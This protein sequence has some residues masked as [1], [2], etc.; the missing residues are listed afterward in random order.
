[1]IKI[2]RILVRNYR[3]IKEIEFTLDSFVAFVGYNNSG[4]SNCMRA[5]NWIL[6]MEKPTLED[7]YIDT[8]GKCERTPSVEYRLSGLTDEALDKLVDDEGKRKKIKQMRIG[9]ELYLKRELLSGKP[10]TFYRI[11]GEWKVNPSGIDTAIKAIHPDVYLIEPDM[12]SSEQAGRVKN[13]TAL[14]DLMVLLVKEPLKKYEEKLLSFKNELFLDDSVREMEEGIKGYLQRYYPGF[15]VSLRNNFEI[16]DI[17]K[18]FALEVREDGSLKS[19]SNYGHGLQRSALMAVLTFL[20]SV[21]QVS[22][23]LKSR[24]LLIDEPE[25]FQ[26]PSMIKK[27]RDTLLRLSESGFQVVITTHSPHLLSA[28]KVLR[29]TYAVS[30]DMERGTFLRN[31]SLAL[32][33]EFNS[34]TLS[35][36][37]ALDQLSYVPFSE[38]IMVVEGGTEEVFF[39]TVLEDLF[40]ESFHRY[41][42]F[43]MDGCRQFPYTKDF[44]DFYGF[45]MMLVGDLDAIKSFRVEDD[46]VQEKIDCIRSKAVEYFKEEG[47]A[48][49]DGGWPSEN[50]SRR[51]NEF[52]LSDFARQKGVFDDLSWLDCKGVHFWSRGDIEH[53]LYPNFV[54]GGKIERVRRL[55]RKVREAQCFLSPRESWKKVIVDSGGDFNELLQLLLKFTRVIRTSME[56]DGLR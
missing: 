33:K 29:R 11:N 55:I 54:D 10:K 38:R 48:L 50:S 47:C 26:H 21:S 35:N 19:L 7:Y 27:I 40:P 1:M 3:S 4:K 32:D 5:I 8:E 28:E 34:K 30:K 24:V 37:L 14:S 25:L 51:F 12:S 52:S 44:L 43:K 56:E 49:D 20:A 17:F 13:G 23:G 9:G 6:S 42:I 16:A 15:D 39:K 45:P 41:S 22:T 53:T 18:S 46:E 2:D 31:P 36:F